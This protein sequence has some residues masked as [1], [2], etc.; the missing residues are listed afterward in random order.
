MA[1]ARL[2]RDM[3]ITRGRTSTYGPERS[4][5]GDL[6]LPAGVGPHPLI[7]LIHG[8]S[9]QSRYG[10]I[11]MRGLAR[12]LAGGGWAVWNIE[13][14]RVG[15]GGGWPATF[16]DVAAA[17]D[18][19]P[20][21]EE[22]AQLDLDRAVVLGHSAGGQLALWAASRERLPPGAPGEIDGEPRLRFREA[23]SLAGVCDLSSAYRW[24]RGGAAGALMGG[25]PDE[26]PDRY[27]AAD[28]MRLLPAPMPVLLVHGSADQTVSVE[29]SRRYLQ[30]ARAAGG[31]AELVEVPGEAG[32]HRAH[33]DPAGVAWAEVRSRLGAAVPVALDA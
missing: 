23:V 8:G 4:Q 1:S 31:Q 12:D 27:D 5:R 32:A 28:P 18:H 9:W 20:E 11:V 29:H 3:L 7:V 6:H 15:D 17:V 10:R 33:I 24:D 16:A 25:G 13:Y 26:F 22:V 30:A 19:V 21:L 14:R 2:I